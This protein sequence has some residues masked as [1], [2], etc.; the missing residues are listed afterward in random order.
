MLKQRSIHYLRKV[1]LLGAADRIRFQIAKRREKHNNMEF[2]R[3][4]LDF[5]RPPLELIYDA[6]GSVSYESFCHRGVATSRWLSDLIR[7]HC[8]APTRIL[9]WGCGPARL[10]R[11]IVNF[12]PEAAIYGAD[13][14][15]QSISWCRS[16]FKDIRFVKN[17]LAPPLPFSDK[18]FD[19][20]YAVSVLTHLSSEQQQAWMTELQRVL[21][22]DGCMVIT[23]QGRRSSRLLLPKEL[24]QFQES[25]MV[26]RDRVQE[27]KRSFVTYH[28]PAYVRDRLFAGMEVVKH[29]A[30]EESNN[31][32]NEQDVWI[33]VQP[34][35]ASSLLSNLA[36]ERRPGSFS[37]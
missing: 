18:F 27:G 2:C 36:A 25:G 17:E 14:N 22:F 9:E 31:G 30:G 26:V 23:T 13:Y 16:V 5:I 28:N 1:G 37:K 20:V 35:R 4:N 12:F 29:I 19:V 15:D 7:E 34:R 11:H 3:R 32:T 6:H 33:L 10:L 21:S 24:K 8:S